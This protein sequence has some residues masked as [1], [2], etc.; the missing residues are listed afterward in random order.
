MGKDLSSPL[1][2]TELSEFHL[3]T[4]PGDLKTSGVP[5]CSE[6]F[7]VPCDDVGELLTL[8][9]A[10]RELL[11]KMPKLGLNRCKLYEQRVDNLLIIC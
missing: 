8:G 2:G 4:S 5:S 6:L 11:K 10:L 1:Q 9:R 7:R 3:G